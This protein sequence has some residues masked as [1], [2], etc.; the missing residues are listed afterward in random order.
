[1]TAWASLQVRFYLSYGLIFEYPQGIGV[2]LVVNVIIQLVESL[3][4]GS[5]CLYAL[6]QQ[7]FFE[8]LHANADAALDGAEWVA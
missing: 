5:F 2:E 7:Q 3:R 8:P 4:H 6:C 1:M